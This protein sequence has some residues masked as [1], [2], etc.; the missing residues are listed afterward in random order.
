MKTMG[1]RRGTS[2]HEDDKTNSSRSYST[3]VVGG[4]G[5]GTGDIVL[6]TK[7]VCDRFL[8]GILRLYQTSIDGDFQWDSGSIL[9]ISGI[10]LV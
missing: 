1:T 8:N 4:R 5:P 10:L 7:V 2:T 9:E 6:Y 3:T